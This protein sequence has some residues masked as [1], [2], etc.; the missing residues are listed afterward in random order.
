[1]AKREVQKRAPATRKSPARTM[2]VMNADSAKA[3]PS[4]DAISMRAYELFLSRGGADGG[5]MH[6]WFLAEREL[7]TG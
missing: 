5:D 6:D 4:H 7:R 1:M 2:Q 3:E